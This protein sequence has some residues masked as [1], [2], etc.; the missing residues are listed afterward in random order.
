MTLLRRNWPSL[1]L[2]LALTAVPAAPGWADL[3]CETFLVPPDETV[4]KRQ[5]EQMDELTVGTYN[6][7]NFFLQEGKQKPGKHGPVAPQ[8]PDGKIA[9]VGR[10]LADMNLDVAVIE[11]VESVDAL[12]LLNKRFLDNKYTPILV[13]G[14]DARGINVGF[15]VKK[16]LPFVIEDDSFRKETWVDPRVRHKEQ[17]LL[18]SRDLPVLVFR[19]PGAPKTAPPLFIFAGTHYKS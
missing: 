17:T 5:L 3:S 8:K 13:K 19:T 12:E 15:L 1:L 9:G 10:A 4:P 7:E 6:V 18:F 11:E 16:D 2:L 14:N